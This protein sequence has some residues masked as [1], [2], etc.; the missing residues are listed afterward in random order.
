[1]PRNSQ[2]V[3]CFDWWLILMAILKN[4]QLQPAKSLK[5]HE[6]RFLLL[7]EM[8]RNFLRLSKLP[9]ASTLLAESPR[10]MYNPNRITTEHVARM[11][12]N[13][14]LC[15]KVGDV[16]ITNDGATI[17]KQLDVEHPAAKVLVELADLQ[18]QEVMGTYVVPEHGNLCLISAE[19][20]DLCRF[21]FSPPGLFVFLSILSNRWEMAQHLLLLWRRSC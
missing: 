10:K 1:M 6:G 11:R 20:I 9:S 14:T 2:R 15:V 12:N 5:G 3:S 8:I 18:D 7:P 4:Y 13:Q 17:L 19:T 16:T 21:V